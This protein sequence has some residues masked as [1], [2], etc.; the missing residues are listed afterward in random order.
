MSMVLGITEVS[1][2]IAAA[3]VLVGVAYYI[4]I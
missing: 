2:I 1:A 3:G 4:W